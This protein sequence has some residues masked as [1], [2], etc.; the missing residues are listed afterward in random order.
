MRK[1]VGLILSG[2]VLLSVVVTV[3]SVFAAPEEVM[4]TPLYQVRLEQGIDGLNSPAILA[5]GEEEDVRYSASTM[6]DCTVVNPPVTCLRT[7]CPC[8]GTCGGTYKIGRCK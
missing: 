2:F 8:P 5:E 7:Q 4:F 3:V 6:F 1:S